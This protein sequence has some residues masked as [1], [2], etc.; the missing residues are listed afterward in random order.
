MWHQK[1]F[2]QFRTA[3]IPRWWSIQRTIH[4]Q[5][6]LLTAN[7]DGTI[8]SLRL[9]VIEILIRFRHWL[10][11]VRLDATFLSGRSNEGVCSIADSYNPLKDRCALSASDEKDTSSIM[12]TKELLLPLLQLA[13]FLLPL[14]QSA[15]VLTNLIRNFTHVGILSSAQQ[16]QQPYHH[17]ANTIDHNN[18]DKDDD[19]DASRQLL[20]T[21]VD[22]FLERIYNKTTTTTQHTCQVSQLSMACLA[23]QQQGNASDDATFE[24][25]LLSKMIQCDLVLAEGCDFRRAKHCCHKSSSSS[26]SSSW[27]SSWPSL[28]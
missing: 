13:F 9:L 27:P 12:R 28:S 11:C 14:V 20:S 3:T 19:S 5:Q 24:V 4:Q 23:M 7:I 26:S 22:E 1:R 6:C 17:H 25:L 8:V 10:L 2:F 21:L 18:G 15:D 16:Q